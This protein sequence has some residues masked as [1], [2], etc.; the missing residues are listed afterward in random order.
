VFAALSAFLLSLWHQR[1]G[2]SL[3]LPVNYNAIWV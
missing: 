3:I 1:C 2:H